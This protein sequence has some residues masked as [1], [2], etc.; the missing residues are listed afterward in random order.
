MLSAVPVLGLVCGVLGISAAPAGAATEHALVTSAP[1]RTATAPTAASRPG[2]AATMTGSANRPAS[3]QTCIPTDLPYRFSNGTWT[4]YWLEKTPNGCQSVWATS[5]QTFSYE[6]IG[7]NGNV[8]TS[9]T[10]PAGFC[11]LW[12]PATN[13]VPFYV[14]DY[15]DTT[16]SVNIYY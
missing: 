1:A 2:P 7:V 9:G 12:D 11:Q 6:L 10:C 8:I 14:W 3:P 4:T 15:T 16:T 13:Y 5:G